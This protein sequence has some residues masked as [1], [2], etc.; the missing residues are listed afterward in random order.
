MYLFKMAHDHFPE[1]EAILDKRFPVLDHGFLRLVDYMGTDKRILDAARVSYGQH[2]KEKTREEDRRL[3]RRLIRDKHTTPFE[4][5]ELTYQHYMQ[6]GFYDSPKLNHLINHNQIQL[7]PIHVQK[8]PLS[9]FMKAANHVREER[10]RTLEKE[11]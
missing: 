1:A 7:Y 2:E 9:I 11:I 3:I 8:N 6:F 5:V 10:K 4:M